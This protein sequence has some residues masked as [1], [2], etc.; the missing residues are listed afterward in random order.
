[1]IGIGIIGKKKE[2]ISIYIKDKLY[3][4]TILKLVKSEIINIKKND[5]NNYSILIG[6]NESN[7]INKPLKGI[8]K[9]YK[10]NNYKNILQFN[11][12]T[13]KNI[14]SIK[15]KRNIDF[16]ILKIGE[17]IDIIGKSIGKG[18]QGVVKRY[19]F[20]GVGEKS[21]GQHN[22]LRSPGSIGAGTYPGKVF[23]GTKMA[24]RMGNK[25]ITVKNIKI[26]YINEKYNFL[27][28]KGSVPGKI[29]KYLI[30]KKKYEKFNN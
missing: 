5:I 10:V 17:K 30:I 28:V 12:I 7:K 3:V 20:S 16:T 22:R 24:G 6:Y 18:F 25:R 11:K 8:F 29:N 26:L 15:N 2:M 1:M 23:K 13:Y 4:C 19:N 9:K 27:L 21:H 14:E